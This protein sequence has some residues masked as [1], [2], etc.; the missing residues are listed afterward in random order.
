[1]INFLKF[2]HV[3]DFKGFPPGVCV[4]LSFITRNYLLVYITVTALCKT[5]A[6]LIYIE[7]MIKFF[8]HCAFQIFT[9][10]WFEA[11]TTWSIRIKYETKKTVSIWFYITCV[12]FN[13]HIFSPWV[14]MHKYT[15]LKHV[16]NT[17]QCQMNNY[18]P[19]NGK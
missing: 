15:N 16:K 19:C 5:R 10:Q 2:L 13:K 18:T 1:M 4:F 8:S 6:L 3:N 17:Y 11:A 12:A 9:W 14:L 7:R